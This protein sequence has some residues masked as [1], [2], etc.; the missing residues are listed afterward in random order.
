M[1]IQL[2]SRECTGCGACVS[3][4]SVGAIN[5]NERADGFLYPEIDSD[6]CVSCGRCM[7]VCPVNEPPRKNAP[8]ACYAATYAEDPSVLMKSSSGGMFFVLAQEILSR[9]GVV[10]GCVFDETYR[11]V[12]RRAET[13]EAL[14]PMHGSKYV[15]SSATES[16]PSVAEDLKNGR[17][18]LY[19]SLPCQAAGLRKYL[20][21]DYDTL[22]VADVLCNGAPSPFAFRSYLSTLTDA[23][24]LSSLHFSFRDKEL[25]GAGVDCT[26]YIRGEKKHEDNLENSFY[27]S[28]RPMC[29]L[30]WR[31]SCYSCAY[32]D[33][34]RVSDIT[35]GDFWGVQK[36]HPSMDGKK[37]VSAVLIN[38][39]KGGDLYAAVKRRLTAEESR[40]VFVTERNSL[41]M[42]KGEGDREIPAARDAFFDTL[43]KDGWRAAEKS[44]LFDDYRT[45]M[46]AKRKRTK[47]RA[48]LGRIKRKIG[49]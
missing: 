41:V 43:R 3:S 10:Y 38:T 7:R 35:I 36:H 15:W 1:T 45:E 17:A 26:Y 37:G 5:M 30:T 34:M 40:T 42:Q 2:P 23:A 8:S 39:E 44:F 12:I 27:Y 46:L 11:A 9:G 24:G 32:K 16:F 14:A 19:T 48:F 25:H 20:G 29:R 18:V 28:F 31:L 22:Y 21:R 47:R 49:L 33:T 4:C 6:K 13:I